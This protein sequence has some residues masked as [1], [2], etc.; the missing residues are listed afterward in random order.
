MQ[1]QVLIWNADASLEIT[2]FTA[3]LR[4]FA[5]VDAGR[6][7]IHVSDLSMEDAPPGVFELAHRWAMDGETVSFESASRGKTYRVDV[8]PLYGPTGIFLGVTGSATEIGA[9]IGERGL[10][11]GAYAQAEHHA[12]IG[13]WHEDLRT[14]RTAISGGLASLLGIDPNTSTLDIR[15]YDHPDDAGEIAR[16]ESHSGLVQLLEYRLLCGLSPDNL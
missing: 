15:Q 11:P 4:D 6:Q 14:G 8:A 10:R 2:S 12:G 13:F 1:D 16:I 9:R 5:G 3:R 7:R